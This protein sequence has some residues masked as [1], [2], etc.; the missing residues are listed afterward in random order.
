MKT[1][2]WTN[3]IIHI[4]LVDGLL[5]LISFVLFLPSYILRWAGKWNPLWI[6][7]E[8]PDCMG[9]PQEAQDHIGIQPTNWF[10][11]FLVAY[12]EC[13]LRN[14]TDNLQVKLALKGQQTDHHFEYCHQYTYDLI[15]GRLVRNEWNQETTTMYRA[16]FYNDS[17]SKVANEGKFLSMQKSLFGKGLVYFKQNGR[18]LVLYT[19]CEITKFENGIFHIREANIGA[20]S[21]ILIRNKHQ[22]AK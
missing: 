9:N 7:L 15:N 12:Y 4:F 11:R 1:K 5:R 21:R 8:D 6:F 2:A 20:A 3:V 16:K 17:P 14:P 22:K 18:W 10:K 19:R 13:V